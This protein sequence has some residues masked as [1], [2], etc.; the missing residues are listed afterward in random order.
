MERIGKVR[1]IGALA[2]AVML[3]L[4]LSACGGDSAPASTPTTMPPT[5]PPPTQPPPTPTVA[6]K[7]NGDLLKEALVNQKDVKSFHIDFILQSQASGSV[8]ANGDV[9]VANKQY[10]LKGAANGQEASIIKLSDTE[11]YTSTNGV[12]WVKV[13]PDAAA[14]TAASFDSLLT[15]FAFDKGKPES[16]DKLKDAPKDG[17]PRDDTIG[18]TA[19]RHMRVDA[20][21]FDPTGDGSGATPRTLTGTYDIWVS[22]NDKP[23]LR[24][25]ELN[26]V[27]QGGADIYA[28]ITWT[29]VDE[30]MDIK[31]PANVQP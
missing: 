5:Q 2:V 26:G 27:E 23:T 15:A 19:V 12:D 25:V 11:V 17:T 21:D 28:R 10:N 4:V 6:P 31:A 29:K 16:V 7:S 1:Y 13:S 22:T 20:K 30:A 24:Q 9:D 14:Q 3:M 8:E 18:G